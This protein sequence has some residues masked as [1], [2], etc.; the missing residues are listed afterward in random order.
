MTKNWPCQV[1]GVS[2]WASLLSAFL[3]TLTSPIR[4]V[5]LARSVPYSIRSLH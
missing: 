1:V 2:A 4:Y 5:F 3:P